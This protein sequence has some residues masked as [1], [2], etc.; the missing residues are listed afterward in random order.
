MCFGINFKGDVKVIGLDGV[1]KVIVV[2]CEFF[3][4]VVVIGGVSFENVAFVRATGVDG[5]VVIFVVV[6]V[7]DVKKVVYKLLY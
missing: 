6:N 1:G 2:V 5:I 3:L 7:V 4:L